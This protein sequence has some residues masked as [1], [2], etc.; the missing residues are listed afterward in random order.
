MGEV[1]SNAVR[2][3]SMRVLKFAILRCLTEPGQKHKINLV[4]RP[5]QRGNLE[6]QLDAT[7][8]SQTRTRA[9]KA[10]EELKTADY[11]RSTY[12]DLGDPENWVQITDRGRSALERHALDKLDEVLLSIDPYLVEIR[13]GAWSACEACTCDSLRQAAHSGRELFD[14]VLRKAAPD[15]AVWG[16]LEGTQAQQTRRPTRRERLRYI[17]NQGCVHTSDS[18]LKIVERAADFALAVNDKLKASA[19]AG[20]TPLKADVVDALNSIEL[21]LRKLLEADGQD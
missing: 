20:S 14:Q 16:S 1:G 3:P 11:I 10:F 17:M 18:D 4:G 6:Y 12:G 5:Y 7:F 21:A 13:D 15:E 19:H 8:D 9:A 2:A